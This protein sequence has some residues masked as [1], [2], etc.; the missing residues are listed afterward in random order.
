MGILG[1][2]DRTSRSV[3]NRRGTHWAVRE[4]KPGTIVPLL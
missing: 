4:P 3:R 2:L 1:R